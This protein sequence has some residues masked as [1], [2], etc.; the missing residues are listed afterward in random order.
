MYSRKDVGIKNKKNGIE[1]QHHS[2][3]FDFYLFF[4]FK[5]EKEI[6]KFW[7]FWW[8]THAGRL[9]LCCWHFFFFAYYNRYMRISTSIIVSRVWKQNKKQNKRRRA[10]LAR[11]DMGGCLLGTRL[12]TV[13]CLKRRELNFEY[14]NRGTTRWIDLTWAHQHRTATAPSNVAPNCRPSPNILQTAEAEKIFSEIYLFKKSIDKNLATVW[15][16]SVTRNRQTAR[17]LRNDNPPG[18]FD[19][20]PP[21]HKGRWGSR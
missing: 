18:P 6:S 13:E 4:L 11:L 1:F 5:N 16:Y 10:G 19:S 9:L 15:Y 2:F 8:L 12:Y 3:L 14:K 17:R 7:L 21:S 20:A